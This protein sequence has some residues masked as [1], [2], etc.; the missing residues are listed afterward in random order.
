MTPYRISP[1]VSF[2]ESRLIPSAIQYGVFH[3]LTG[4]VVE[5][6]QQL[7]ALLFAAK[8]G[9]P[10]S[11]TE[12][13]LTRLSPRLIF[14]QFLIPFNKD[15]L[16][17]FVDFQV[18]RPLQNPALAYRS[19]QGTISIVRVSMQK[20]IYSPAPNEL[21]AVLEETMSSPALEIFQFADGTRTMREIFEQ[22]KCDG[23]LLSSKE[24]RAAVDFLT[25][26]ERQLIKLTSR[27]ADLR[28]PFRPVNTVPRNFYHSSRW[29]S[30]SASEGVLEFHE[31]GIEDATWEFD[32]IEPTVNHAL[33]FSTPVLGNLDYGAAFCRATLCSEVLPLLENRS[34]IDLLEVG[35]GTGEFARAFINHARSLSAAI[36]PVDVNYHILDLSPA[37]MR[38]QRS[39]LGK[40]LPLGNHFRQ[41]AT[42]MDLPGR[43]FDLIISNE[44][45]ADF[46]VAQ[47]ER[48]GD[49]CYRG[50]GV[51]YVEEYGLGSLQ[52]PDR[53]LVN[54][55]AFKFIQRAWEH[56]RPGGTLIVS[57]YG[58]FERL[59]VQSFHLNHAEY[60]IHFGHL[61][62]AAKKTG[63]ECR[64]LRLQQFLGVD[65]SVAVL[66]GR[67]ERI[68][69][70]NH[71][72]Q[73]HGKALPYALLSQAQFEREFGSL[74]ET[75]EIH[76]LS[77]SPLKSGYHFGPNIDDFMVMIMIRPDMK[78]K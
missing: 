38:S 51:A 58:S 68:L 21:P 6:D 10:I 46:P 42:M 35:G 31:S 75:L 76:G 13:N 23:D 30:E 61:L 63:F 74:V 69:C 72:L 16:S 67:E 57:E 26:A 36:R 49:K 39:V 77:F 78:S 73:K 43:T 40:D 44:V 4:E 59:P 2:I 15:P 66:D 5:P 55:G 64:L 24:F 50:E 34:Q 20:R 1:Y 32:Q 65:E 62:A 37:I 12:A 45:M 9:T 54:A 22:L 8:S 28:D 56:L 25:S 18:A 19:E 14:G 3:R 53:F 27:P 47:V 52:L 7:R 60:S 70:L 48:A 17:S 11:L 33:R 71:I 41:D 29:E